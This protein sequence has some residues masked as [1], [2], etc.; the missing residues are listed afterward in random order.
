M[1]STC[2]RSNEVESTIYNQYS[3]LHQETNALLERNK[4]GQRG[5]GMLAESQPLLHKILFV[6]KSSFNLIP[7]DLFEQQVLAT[8][9]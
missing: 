4:G 2:H 1:F 6:P 9:I 8:F 5:D 7:E 3:W